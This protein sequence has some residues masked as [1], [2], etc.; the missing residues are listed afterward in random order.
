M[1]EKGSKLRIYTVVDVWRGLVVGVRNF[2]RLKNAEFY[3]RRLMVQRNLRED[4][5]QLFEAT[6]PFSSRR[7]LLMQLAKRVE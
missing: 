4:D 7:K 5:V 1:T 2:R 3:R 6:L